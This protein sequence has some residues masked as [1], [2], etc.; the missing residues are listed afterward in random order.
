MA[1][2]R[3]YVGHSSTRQKVLAV[4]LLAVMGLF[5]AVGSLVVAPA[6]YQKEAG[7]VDVSP[8]SIGSMADGSV[9]VVTT[10]KEMEGGEPFVLRNEEFGDWTR[11]TGEMIGE[12][13]YNKITLEDG[14]VLAAKIRF[15]AETEEFVREEGALKADYEHT[16]VTY[17]IGV[18]R[19]WP[20]EEQELAEAAGWITYKDG[21]ADMEGDF[22]VELPDLEKMKTDWS[23]KMLAA[24]LVAGL[25][26]TTAVDLFMGR[27]EG[28]ASTPQTEQEMWI[29]GTYANWAQN[30][31]Q[32]NYKG[33]LTSPNTVASPLYLGGRPK[34][35]D[36]KKLTIKVLKKDWGIKTREDLL[37]T[38]EYMSK[39]SGFWDCTTQ[40]GRAWELC[41]ST[42]LL[43]MG[44]IAGW[45]TKKEMLERSSVVGNIIQRV[46]GGWEELSESY[47]EAYTDWRVQ[48]SGQQAE[49]AIV[50]RRQIQQNLNNRKDSPYR[51]PWMLPLGMDSE[52]MERVKEK[53][54]EV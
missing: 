50:M 54:G 31:G 26:A 52:R 10:L 13:Y 8:G 22:G 45:L 35:E 21:Y 48:V 24:G 28:R 32:L 3:V 23:L 12:T 51:L 11:S 29:L 30:F 42:Q 6:L 17:P 53:T 18:M 36:S 9:P 33:R 38:V 5:G 44:Y 46:F 4:G 2:T 14:T 27:K 41:R 25:A 19:P 37:D 15:E 16:V 20:Q 43:G 39:G 7:Q 1:V 40:S 34:D 49:A 47:L